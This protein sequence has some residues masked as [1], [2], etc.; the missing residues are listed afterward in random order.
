MCMWQKWHISSHS[1]LDGHPAKIPLTPI[2]SSRNLDAFSSIDDITHSLCY[3][4]IIC[5]FLYKY[6]EV[7]PSWTNA[8]FI[9]LE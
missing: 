2:H 6:T 5:V 3:S 9:L 1:R 7:T 8:Q 4:L